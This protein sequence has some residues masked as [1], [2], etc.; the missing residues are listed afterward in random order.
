MSDVINDPHSQTHSPANRDHYFL[1]QI[2]LFCA[3]LK[4]GDGRTEDI[5]ES[6]DHYVW[7]YLSKEWSILSAKYSTR[8]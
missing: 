4:S 5:S 8:N 7:F 6:S 3:I 2:V 1:L